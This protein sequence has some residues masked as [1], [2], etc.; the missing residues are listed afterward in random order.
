MQ[1]CTWMYVGARHYYIKPLF[2]SLLTLFSFLPASIMGGSSSKPSSNAP[3]EQVKI[4]YVD[5]PV[6]PPDIEKE[7]E[8]MEKKVTEIMPVIT[9]DVLC[10]VDTQEDALVL[11]YENLQDLSMI[12]ENVEQIFEKNPARETILELALP[13]LNAITL[14]KEMKEASRYH[15]VEKVV[16][17]GDKV[18]G[19]ELHCKMKI[20]DETKGRVMSTKHTSCVIGYKVMVHTMNLNPEDY[21]TPEDM[22]AI[23]F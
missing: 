14:N 7:R 11:N 9:K 10:T 12:K 19:L 18:F 13:L 20:I 21:P 2:Y 1:S 4:R 23:M 15:R 22:K 8:N 3:V 16:R 6:H 17:K 5:A